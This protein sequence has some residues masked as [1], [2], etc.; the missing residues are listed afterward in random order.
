MSLDQEYKLHLFEGY[1]IELEYMLVNK[2]TLK[3][4]PMADQVLRT[5]AGEDVMAVE[6]GEIAWSNELALHVIEIKSNG[7]KKDLLALQKEMFKAINAMNKQLDSQSAC[8]LP[9][10]MHPFFDPDKDLKLWDAENS[11]IYASYDRIFSCKGHGWANLQ[12]IHINLPFYDD[13]EFAKL[14]AAIRLVLPLLP[15]L[16][17]SSPIVEGKRGPF[18]DSRLSFYLQNQRRIKSIIGEAIPEAVTSQADYKQKILQ[19]MYRDIAPH[20]PTGILQHEWLNSRTAIARFERNAVEIRILDIQECLAADFAIISYVT[21][22]IEALIGETWA[23]Q[24]TQH[25]IELK[26]LREIMD[27]ALNDGLDGVISNQCYLQCFGLSAPQTI[28]D[29]ISHQVKALPTKIKQA[30]SPFEKDLDFILKD[31]NAAT[32]MLRYLGKDMSQENITRLFQQLAKCLQTNQLLGS[33]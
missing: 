16:A 8:L 24:S 14:H 25:S 19:P 13:A 12:S 5:L 22:L 6:M 23:K 18:L 15:A 11:E 17:A 10:A 32:R 26:G 33:K 20:D 9:T 28:R 27:V 4:Q 7:P 21:S 2:E 30:H 31:G 3:T 1:G 29:V